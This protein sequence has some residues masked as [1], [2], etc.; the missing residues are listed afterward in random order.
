M[1]IHD[2]EGNELPNHEVGEV[3][4][5][6]HNVMKDYL[7]R[8]EESKIAIRNGWFYTGD[9]GKR[10]DD[11]YFYIVDR[12]KDMI[13]KD[14]FNVY[15]REIEECIINHKSVSL[16]AVIGV[17]DEK[18]GEEIKAVIQL[19]EGEIISKSQIGS[20]CR[21]HLANYKLPK[22]IEFIDTLPTSAT[23]KILKRELK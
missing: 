1:Q 19:K 13:I 21:K 14:G 18:H 4:I 10:D 20:Y 23:G 17:P 11:N 12:S 22:I 3:V 6:G 5:K 9:L 2:K 7:N 8:P 15:P 16:V